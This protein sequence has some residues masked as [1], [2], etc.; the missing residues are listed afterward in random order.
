MSTSIM[1]DRARRLRHA[2]TDAERKLWYSLRSRQLKGVKFRRQHPV[3]GY[4]ADFC[5][6]ERRLIVEVD[7]GQHTIQT[8][9]DRRRTEVLNNYGYRVLRFWDH[10][11]LT[12]FDV[13]LEC[14]AEELGPSPQP[15]PR[16]RGHS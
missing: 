3:A 10:E 9:A 2:Q 8:Q 12:N 1:R 15:S 14:I 5:C 4:I 6:V 13:V 11:V 7:G 16:G